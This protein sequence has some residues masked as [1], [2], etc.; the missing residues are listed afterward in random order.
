MGLLPRA[1]CSHP[2]LQQ[3]LPW[4]MQKSQ[5]SGSEPEGGDMALLDG[6]CCALLSCDSICSVFRAREGR[7]AVLAHSEQQV[8]FWAAKRWSS[9]TCQGEK[10][11]KAEQ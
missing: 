10:G 1:C 3:A 8:A 9:E 6:Y 4:H 5:H 2:L 11:S 7:D